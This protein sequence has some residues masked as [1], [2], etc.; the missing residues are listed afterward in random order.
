MTSVEY[1]WIAAWMMFR[2]KQFLP[3]SI[4]VSAVVRFF[5]GPSLNLTPPSLA[6]LVSPGLMET[7]KTMPTMTAKAVVER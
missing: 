2:G 6:V 4:K 1:C 7:T 3:R 5:V